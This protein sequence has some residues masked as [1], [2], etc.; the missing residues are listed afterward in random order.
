MGFKMKGFTYPGKSS[1]GYQKDSPD[2]NKPSNVIPSNK[3]TMKEKDGKPLQKGKIIG[4]GN[5][6][7]NKK[8][9]KPGKDYTF[10]GDTEVLET[11]VKYH[12]GKPHWKS[13]LKTRKDGTFRKVVTKSKRGSGNPEHKGLFSGGRYK[14]V[15][16]FDKSGKVISAK[17]NRTKNKHKKDPRRIS[18]ASW[19]KRDMTPYDDMYTVR[20]KKRK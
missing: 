10:K 9:M 11:P 13:K 14:S 1:E 6:T 2:R 16:K 20:S 12:K 4:I 8:I 7:G 17:N 15:I 5:K 19:I 3:I 18:R